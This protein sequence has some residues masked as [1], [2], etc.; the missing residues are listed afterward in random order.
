[1]QTLLGFF[2]QCQGQFGTFLYIDPSDNAVTAQ[3]I[4]T[5]DGV[6][7]VFPLQRTIGGFTEPVSTVTGLSGVTVNGIPQTGFGVSGPNAVTLSSPPP[8]GA[9]IAASFTYAF[10]CRF[11]DD[12]QDFENVMNGLWTLASLKFRSIRS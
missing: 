6:T 11:S 3:L 10:L 7:T 9:L 5:G 1:M 2:L 8:A 4:A 12:Q